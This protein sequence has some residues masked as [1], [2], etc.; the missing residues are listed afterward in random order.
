[1]TKEEYISLLQDL[2]L[3]ERVNLYMC[4]QEIR[5]GNI[6]KSKEYADMAKKY[7]YY[8]RRRIKVKLILLFYLEMKINYRN[9][10][11]KADLGI[12][13]GQSKSNN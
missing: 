4:A 11:M 7:S 13:W 3:K 10:E 9:L 2:M 5:A 12:F 6:E 1:M 8:T